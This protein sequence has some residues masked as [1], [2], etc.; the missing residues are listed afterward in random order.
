MG[1]EFAA[2]EKRRQLI[3]ELGVTVVLA[4]EDGQKVVH[5]KCLIGC[6]TLPISLTKS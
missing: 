5:V 6:D 4:V 3:E 1:T 2:F